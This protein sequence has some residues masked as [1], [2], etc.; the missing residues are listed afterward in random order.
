MARAGDE[1]LE[2]LF[3]AHFAPLVRGLALAAGSYE[4]ASDAVQ[5]AF[6]QLHRHWRRVS[7][8]EEPVAWLQR[9]ATNRVANQR[10]GSQRQANLV[11]RLAGSIDAADELD[12]AAKLDLLNAIAALPERQRLVVGL[13]H[14]T[15]MKVSEVAAALDV[16]EGTVKSQ[17]HDAR[18]NLRTALE[19]D[20]RA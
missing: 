17:L 4:A 12:R 15:G 13:H 8:Y 3:Q 20:D 1:E 7:A 6:V 11:E 14:L 16:S 5:D 9:V 18:S 10:R 2:A 19:V